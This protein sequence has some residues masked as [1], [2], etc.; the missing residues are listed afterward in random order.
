MIF[1]GTD[2]R[3]HKNISGQGR[4]SGKGRESDSRAGTPG[5]P[6]HRRAKTTYSNPAIRPRRGR[7]RPCI[8][9]KKIR[10]WKE[11]TRATANRMGR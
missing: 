9:M 1:S 2:D 7:S 5:P 10:A 4:I 6:N 3:R 8:L 11:S